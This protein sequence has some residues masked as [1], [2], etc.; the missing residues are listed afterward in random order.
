[1]ACALGLAVGS[2]HAQAPWPTRAVRIVLPFAAGGSTDAIARALGAKLSEA[3]GQPVVIDNR[4]G[5]GG[6]IAA[7]HVAQGSMDGYTLLMSTTSTQVILPIVN[8]KLG[9]DAQRDFAPIVMVAQAPNLL[10]A[11]PTLP[12]TKLAD[13]ISLARAKPG[14]FTF[15][16]SGTGTITHLIGEAFAAGAGIKAAHAPY[17]TGVQAIPD[18]V[19]GQIA[20][21][22]DSIV[23]TLPQVRAGKLKGLAITSR[24]RSPLAPELPTVAESGLSGFEGITWFALVI[25]SAVSRDLVGRINADVNRALRSP[26]LKDRLAAQG[27][28]ASGGS[29]SDVWRAVR[30]DTTRWERVIREAGIRIE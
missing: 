3:W 19:S 1:M 7:E 16:S 15:A 14:A 21:Q 10:V 11:S 24:E 5:A 25:H 26:D 29:P 28:E 8:R 9:Y 27:A 23:W 20:W 30:D 4:P 18:L 6:A 13:L 17:K 2:V 12:V 22:F